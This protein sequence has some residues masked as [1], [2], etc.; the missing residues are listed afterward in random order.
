MSAQAVSSSKLELGSQH[1]CEVFEDG[2]F[3]QLGSMN[4]QEVV[5]GLGT[6]EAGNGR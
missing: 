6:G 1:P 2:P 4:E 5:M 3:G